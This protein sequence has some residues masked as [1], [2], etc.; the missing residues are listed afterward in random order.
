MIMNKRNTLFAL[1]AAMLV[2]GCTVT[3]P[4]AP[5]RPGVKVLRRAGSA[6]QIKRRDAF[7]KL[8]SGLPVRGIGLF[9]RAFNSGYDNAEICRFLVSCGFNRAYFC[10]TSESE[11]DPALADFLHSANVSGLKVEAVLRQRDFYSRPRGNRVLR[12]M[13]NEY[14]DLAAAVKHVI[15]FNNTLPP[16]SRICGITVQVEPHYFTAGRIG[17]GQIYAW[18]EKAFGPGLDND[19]LVRE[20]LAMLKKIDTA[21]LPLT[22]G[23]PDSYHDLAEENKISCGKVQDF[24][25]VC[26]PAPV[27]MLMS[28]GN[29]PGEVITRAER[30]LAAAGSAKTLLGITLADHT[31]VAANGLRRRDWNDLERILRYVVKTAVRKSGGFEGVVIQPLAVFEN[32]MMEQD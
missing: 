26:S 23:V 11:L 31:S 19:M 7:K 29:K 9:H 27:I 5:V 22:I 24:A 12:S 10:I 16:E 2:C 32:I 1:A 30:E 21:G 13:S 17:S 18:S 14:P 25:A 28:S 3:T 8:F 6:E 15:A 20:T 4:Q